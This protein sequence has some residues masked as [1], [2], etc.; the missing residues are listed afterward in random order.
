[1]KHIVLL[2]Y[3]LAFCLVM[4]SCKV[5]KPLQIST[6]DLKYVDSLGKRYFLD[7]KGKPLNGKYIIADEHNYAN[8]TFN[9]GLREGD[10]IQKDLR[11]NIEMHL[12]Y[13]DGVQHGIQEKL[14]NGVIG[15]R[16]NFCYGTMHGVI[17]VFD[18]TGKF[19][20][21]Q[22]SINGQPIEHK[23]NYDRL[24]KEWPCSKLLRAQKPVAT[25][26]IQNKGTTLH[27]IDTLK[28][29]NGVMMMSRTYHKAFFLYLGN[30]MDSIKF[31][32][33]SSSHKVTSPDDFHYATAMNEIVFYYGIDS[34]ARKRQ[35]YYTLGEKV[36]PAFQK[37]ELA[38]L[39][40]LAFLEHDVFGIAPF[41]GLAAAD[42]LEK[43]IPNK[44]D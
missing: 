10:F 30:E 3:T 37:E 41:A 9:Y 1:M 17:T 12:H 7:P 43:A 35:Y 18:E 15:E 25:V 20:K 5:H 6:L 39:T 22:Y 33:F 2:L 42:A 16:N 27:V 28:N 31:T 21:E 24:I 8:G 14:R 36:T 26:S 11:L 23:E 34:I 44:K 4:I 40:V 19:L 13:V 38:V 29:E 32:I